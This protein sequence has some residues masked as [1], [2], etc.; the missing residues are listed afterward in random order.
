MT[1]LPENRLEK[2]PRCGAP[3]G[4]H[5]QFGFCSRCA[6]TVSLGEPE[7]AQP[8]ED[9][10]AAVLPR[11]AAS[12]GS[13][14]RFGD[15]ELL[16][17]IGRG[18]M[19]VV[20]RAR[21]RSLNRIVAVKML[22]F[23]GLAAPDRLRRFQNEAAATAALEHANIVRLLDV[24]EHEGQPF[25]AMEFITGR[26]LAQLVR[27]RPLASR[28][29]AVYVA[30]IARAIEFAHRQGVL[31]RDL[32]PSNVLVDGFDEPC[33]TDFGLARNL[34][35]NTDLTVTGQMLGSPNFMPP[36]QASGNLRRMGPT[37]DV[38]G[39]GAILYH[40]LTARPPFLAETFE[41]TLAAVREREPM[42]PGQLNEKVP[43]D[44]ETICLK[45]LEKDPSRRYETARELADELDRFL[46]DEPI[47]ARPVTRFEHAWRW[48]RRK[49][50]LATAY[51]L[52]LLLILV[53]LIG[54][55]LAALRINQARQGE[56]TQRE[57]AEA[58]GHNAR[59]SAYASDMLLAHQALEK[60]NR[61]RVRELL[62]KHRPSERSE[63]RNP[64][65]ICAVGNGAISGTKP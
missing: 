26:D 64:K 48:C 22:L 23:A 41:A 32:K 42:P 58:E 62:A 56:V 39:L 19:G 53:I 54:S 13:R 29:A 60:N 59:L 30:K 33:V 27:E 65:S 40:L 9:E 24:G 36:E 14:A 38:Y 61:G 63:I 52:L 18:G 43:R 4:E 11:T 51:F 15:Y 3:F 8:S 5:A 12:S 46:K 31:H 35:D 45:C 47:T 7:T 44:L 6:A 17:E 16:E 57:R 21:Q 34:A 1:P 50:A 37:S 20:Y 25:I 49:P 10:L 28:Q 55:P 2:C